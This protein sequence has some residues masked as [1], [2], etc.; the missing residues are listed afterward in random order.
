M[1]KVINPLNSIEARGS[2]GGLTYNTWRGI[3]TVKTRSGPTREPTPDQLQMLALAH[4][5]NAAWRALSDAQRA[6]WQHYAN[7][8]LEPSW[9]GSPI[10]LTAHNWYIRIGVRTQM[11]AQDPPED[12]PTWTYTWDITTLTVNTGASAYWLYWDVSIHPGSTD[13]YLQI[14]RTGPLTPG[15]NPTLHQATYQL[16]QYYPWAPA[17][18]SGLAAGTYTIFIRQLH[19]SGVVGPWHSTRFT[20]T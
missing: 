1:A 12:P 5:A 9:T 17:T 3:R 4:T 19:N 14:Y 13:T 16:N 8:H 6:E 20:I 18:E 7:T 15:R 10:R 11:L 2:V